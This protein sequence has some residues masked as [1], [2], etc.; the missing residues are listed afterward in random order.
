MASTSTS[1]ASSKE[2][3]DQHRLTPAPTMN[4]SA[5]KRSNCAGVV[6]DFHGPAAEHETRP[7]QHREA[8]FG[9][10][11]PG[12]GHGPGDAAGRLLQVQVLQARS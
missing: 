1:V 5:T 6:A 12:L 3:V 9:R 2:T 7:H 4:A 11:G 8:D 10:L